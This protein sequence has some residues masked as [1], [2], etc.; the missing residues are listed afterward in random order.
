LQSSK[1]SAKSLTLPAGLLDEAVQ[2]MANLVDG[3]IYLTHTIPDKVAFLDETRRSVEALMALPVMEQRFPLPGGKTYKAALEFLEEGLKNNSNW[4][5]LVGWAFVHH[6]GKLV[7][8]EEFEFQSLTWLD[9][10]QFNKQ[11]VETYRFMGQDDGASNALIAAIRM[12]VDQQSWYARLGRLPLKELLSHWLADAEVARFLGI[13]RYKDVLW[14]NKESF[15]KFVWWMVA[16]AAIDAASDPLATASGV[17]EQVLG[18]YDV[19]LKLLRAEKYSAFQV[20]KLI[21]AAGK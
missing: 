12:L 14:Y 4:L 11:L 6:L 7:A 5:A 15:D 16:L 9:E 1:L 10:W 21:E 20:Q 8:A 19:A 17:I 18:A 2:K 3:I 13:N